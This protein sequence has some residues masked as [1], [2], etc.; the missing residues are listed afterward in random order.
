MES[1][2]YFAKKSIRIASALAQK[3]LLIQSAAR[4]V[5]F[6]QRSEH[7]NPLLFHRWPN[8]FISRKVHR[9]RAANRNGIKSSLCLNSEESISLTQSEK[10][11]RIESDSLMLW[12]GQ[13]EEKRARRLWLLMLY[14][15]SVNLFAKLEL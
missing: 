12:N 13:S 15:A 8:N 5:C 3:A 14:V 2:R 1:E 7:L 10:K 9:S 4:G 6:V 11:K